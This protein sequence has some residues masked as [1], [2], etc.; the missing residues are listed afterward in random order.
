[1]INWVSDLL[2]WIVFCAILYWLRR[3]RI[4]WTVGA[5]G[6][7]LLFNQFFTPGFFHI[8]L[9]DGHLYGSR[10]D[11][12]NQGAKVMLLSLGMVLVIATGGVDLSVGAV[13]A[14]SAAV[15]SRLLVTE[16]QPAGV[17]IAAALVVC[18]LAGAWN[19]LLV[20]GFGIQPIIATLVL[21]VAGRGVAQLITEGQII[22]FLDPTMVYVGN[23]HLFGLPFTLTIV[24]VML[25]LTLFLVR[26][27][28]L[29]L[30]IESVGDNYEASRYSGINA[31][32]VKFLVY[33]FSGLC[34][35]LAGLV[36]CSNIKSA[37]A[38]NIGLYLE[39]DAILAVV[40]G[41]T[42]LQ[43]GRFYLVGAV[44]GALFI[45]TLTTTLYARNVSS[46]VSPV[47]KAL[48]IIGVCLFQSDLF[49]KRMIQ[50]LR[51]LGAVL[52]P[53][54]DRLPHKIF[55]ATRHDSLKP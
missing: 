7:L 39:L 8:Q 31:A 33:T 23:G 27:T 30:F 38:N 25:V 46:D 2:F 54:S 17:A 45:Q 43:G 21:M 10:I 13:M 35:G 32:Q 11:V 3:Q 22:N 18:V 48:V 14:I 9:L 53:L 51:P 41:G 55:T 20:A 37:D 15:S 34:A 16:N 36:A 26:R 42:S 49:R 28:A 40:V 50:L 1:M 12:L 47:P 52:K 4:F 5:L 29:G 44:V 6:L 19:G 24:L